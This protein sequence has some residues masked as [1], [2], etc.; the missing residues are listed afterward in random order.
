MTTPSIGTLVEHLAIILEAAVDPE[1]L[2]DL[3]E[4]PAPSRLTAT[5]S[6]SGKVFSTGMWLATAHQPARS[7][8]YG[9]CASLP[10]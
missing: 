5:I 4:S 8:Q 1:M 10:Y 7:R 2:L 3:C 9:L 6:Q